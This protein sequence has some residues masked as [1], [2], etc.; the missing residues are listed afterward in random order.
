MAETVDERIERAKAAARGIYMYLSATESSQSIVRDMI[1]I[2]GSGD[3]D[4][5][6]RAMALDTL[7]ETLFG[8]NPAGRLCI[9]RES[10]E[11]SGTSV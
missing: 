11:G 3:S 6:E 10:C 8:W 5:D 9:L 1:S 4:D 2:I 7:D